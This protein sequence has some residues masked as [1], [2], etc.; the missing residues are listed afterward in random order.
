MLA[1]FVV[2]RT[3]N[4]YGDPTDWAPQPTFVQSAMAFMN[5]NKYP[6]SLSYVLVTLVPALLALAALDGRTIAGGFWG[7]VVTF[8]RVPFFFY[9]LQWLTAHVS[10]MIVTAVQGKSLDGYFKHLLDFFQQPARLRRAAVDG[11]RLLDPQPARDLPALPLVRRRQGAAPR[12][13]AELLVARSP[14]GA[15]PMPTVAT[16]PPAN[17]LRLDAIDV[18]RGAVM[19]LMVLD[20]TRQFVHADGLTGHPL[21]LATTTVPLYLTRWVTHLCAPAFVL[22]AGLGIGLRRLRAG[23]EGL[24]WFVFTR[25]LWLVTIELTL[26]RALAWFNLDYATFFAHLQVIWAIGA[27]MIVLSLLVR[28]P[29]VVVAAIGALLIVGHNA[30]DAVQ[31]SPWRPDGAAPAPGLGGAIWMLL[32]Q[33]GFFPIGGP[34]GPV[35]W[36]DYPLLPWLGVLCVGYAMSRLYAWPRE[37]RRRALTLAAVS[38]PVVFVLLRTWNVYG[39][40]RDWA[41]QPT[42]VLVGDVVHEGHEVRPV[43][44]FR[45]GDA[46]AGVRRAGRARWPLL[47]SRDRRRCG[48]L[49]PGA[50]LLLPV[51]MDHRARI[52]HR[53]HPL[54]GRRSPP[55]RHASGGPAAAG[56][57]AERGRRVV[58]GLRLFWILSVIALYPLCRWFAGVKARRRDWWLSYL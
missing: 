51:A 7:A 35:V 53:R 4:I 2:L 6:P 19:I 32:H 56:F 23:T 27:S 11:L 15:R 44:R 48:H 16:G 47:R 9:V 8:G 5:V 34:R 10:G 57:A 17:R 26:V 30:L 55:L 28:L 22:C 54:A 49:R 14:P 12:V 38:M 18:V 33:S 39:D 3:F 58:G 31:V 43:A 50:V 29:V 20:H 46:G 25:G 45:A 52:G 24:P 37:P 40:P 42:V 36:A 41:P 13:V 21:D 1:A